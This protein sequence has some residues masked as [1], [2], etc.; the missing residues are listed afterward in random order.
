V[1]AAGIFLTHRRSPRIRRHFRRL[2]EESGSLVDWHFVYSHDTGARPTTSLVA[3]DPAEVLATR[4]AAMERNGGVQGGY[5]DT[6]LLPLLR[7]LA[8]DQLWAI[9]YDV[10]Y[11][12]RWSDLFDQ[13]ADNDADLLTTTLL[14]RRDQEQWPWWAS[15]GSPSWVAEEQWLRSLNPLMRLSRPL[16]NAYCVAMADPAWRGHYEFTLPTLASVSGFVVEDLGGD[17][18]FTPDAR[19]GRIYV[20]RTPAGRPDDQTFG[21]RPVRRRYFHERPEAFPRAGLVY[22]PVKPGVP[23]WTRETMNVRDTT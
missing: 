11:A 23:A 15:A 1:T 9:E 14:R 8:A 17:G 13:F 20:G 19:R 5:V 3:D 18:P 10:D 2:V 21:F 4:H 7:S 22:H 16:V 6:L 12:G